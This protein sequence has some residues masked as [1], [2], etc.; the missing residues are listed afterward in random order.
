MRKSNDDVWIFLPDARA[1]RND[2]V[3]GIDIGIESCSMSCLTLDKRQ[4]VKSDPFANTLE[5]FDWLFE[6][7]QGSGWRPRKC[8]YDWN[9]L[10][11]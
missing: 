9:D 10:A 5:G 3:V 6:R 8:S 4:V 2:H 1:G 11:L 7:L